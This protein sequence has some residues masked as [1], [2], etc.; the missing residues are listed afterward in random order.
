[1][2]FNLW[3]WVE[4]K[5]HDCDEDGQFEAAEAF[6]AMLRTMRKHHGW[7]AGILWPR[8]LGSEERIAFLGENDDEIL[9]EFTERVEAD[10]WLC[11]TDRRFWTYDEMVDVFEYTKWR[12][13]IPGQSV[14]PSLR[15]EGK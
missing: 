3:E 13:V 5:I 6:E 12:F 9:F 10:N 7:K 2:Q 4:K 8:K 1:M 11:L 14:R 15:E